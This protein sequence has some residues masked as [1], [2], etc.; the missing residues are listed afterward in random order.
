[1]SADLLTYARQLHA[2]GLNV[3]PARGKVPNLTGWGTW[4]NLPIPR[5]VLEDWS[6][7]SDTT[8]LAVCLG[9][10]NLRDIEFDNV[11]EDC[12][13]S[14]METI[15]TRLTGAWCYRSGSRKGLHFLFRC[16]EKNPF[17]NAV[18]QGRPKTPGQFHHAELR[19]EKSLSIVP[20]SKHESGF[21]YE[22]LVEPKEAPPIFLVEQVR[23]AWQALIAEPQKE[24]EAHSARINWNV[25]PGLRHTAL[26]SLVGKLKTSKLSSEILPLALGW[27][28]GLAEPLPEREVVGTVE[29]LCKEL[30]TQTKRFSF[31]VLRGASM[32]TTPIPEVSDLLRG[33]L[34][35]KS[36]NILAGEEGAGKSI[37]AMNLGISVA[38]GAPKFLA[39]PI[40]KP[41]KV[42]FLNNEIF[43]EDFLRRFQSMTKLLPGKGSLDNF[44]A[45]DAVPPLSECFDQLNELIEV[46]KPVLVI[47]DC[48]YFAHNE[49]END[50]SKMK[51]LMRQLQSLRDRHSTC[52][53]VVHHLRKGGRDQ[54][55]NNELMR[56]SGVFGAAADSILM[57]RRSQ[58]E[59]SRRILKATKLRHSGDENKQT[60]LLS[61]N[62]ETLWFHDD[63]PADE[64]E[65]MQSANT[66]SD[67]L[68]FNSILE[69]GEMRFGDILKSVEGYGFNTKTVQRQL[70]KAVES[71][72]VI[73]PRHGWYALP[74]MDMVSK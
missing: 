16:E 52:V 64:G 48:L 26:C 45:P 36:T 39:W 53:V 41:G 3:L 23:A 68:D 72:R 32:N 29:S 40:E 22:W 7:N 33:V 12:F 13:D 44:I 10:G 31:N 11:P 5:H 4:Q 34:R 59:E 46:E 9:F 17:R 43:M 25:E 54:R 58:T 74:E 66:A 67:V 24:V 47:L 60:R 49:D 6:W 35:A 1:M 42:L 38:T 61:L 2:F 71:G 18:T 57:L 14:I 19:W 55:L 27:N 21:L 50:S 51:D 8:G 73:K 28:R 65:H 62:P 30:P 69:A 63:G 15:L 70:D 20:P 37:G 56:G